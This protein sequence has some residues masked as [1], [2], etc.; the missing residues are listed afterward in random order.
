M[1]ISASRD[2]VDNRGEDLRFPIS[3][4]SGFSSP[5]KRGSRKGAPKF[6]AR[7]A[8]TCIQPSPNVTI[9]TTSAAPG[10][11]YADGVEIMRST[12]RFVPVLLWAAVLFVFTCTVSLGL[13]VRHHF[14]IFAF[15]PDPNF[16]EFFQ[17]KDIRTV[18]QVWYVVKLGH[19]LGFAILDLLLYNWL[20]RKNATVV[21]AILFA[22]ATEI[23]QLYFNR[24]GRLYDV[25]IDSLGIL[26]S[27][28][29]IK[30]GLFG[31]AKRINAANSQK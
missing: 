10:A 19:F 26:F 24:D 2:A 25:I 9:R 29:L 8:P 21:I 18:H 17:M 30:W 15:N 22:L 27:Y 11:D 13:L 3:S 23:F 6:F 14:I 20:R 1:K 4:S 28:C 7:I 16:R 12:I 31:P 5:M